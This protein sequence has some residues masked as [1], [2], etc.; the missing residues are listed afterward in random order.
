MAFDA[1]TLNRVADWTVSPNFQNRRN[2]A[3]SIKWCSSP[4]TNLARSKSSRPSAPPAGRS[5][6]RSV[7]G[8]FDCGSALVRQFE[9]PTRTSDH[10]RRSDAVVIELQDISCLM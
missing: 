7:S 3:E 10:E 2:R 1:Q 5:D 6:G 4:A 9:L 8:L